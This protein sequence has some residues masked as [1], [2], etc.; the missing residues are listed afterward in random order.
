M[1][2]NASPARQSAAQINEL[3]LDLW[4]ATERDGPRY[5]EFDLTGKQHAVLSLIATQP[6]LS[7]H[8]LAAALGVTKGAISQH[9]HTLE[10][11]GYISRRRSDRDRRVQVL[12]LEQRGRAYHETMQRFE[13]YTVD[14][15]LNRLSGADIAEIIAALQKL[16]GA[17]EN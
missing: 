11:E 5:D 15:Y 17:F 16:K 8:A 7:P 9:L 3:I 4:I 2:E 10:L 13:Q 6:E 1:T 14:R 12:Q